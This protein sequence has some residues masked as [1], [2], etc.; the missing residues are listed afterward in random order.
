[1]SSSNQSGDKGPLA[2]RA[3]SK[4]ARKQEARKTATLDK[5]S[6]REFLKESEA[7]RESRKDGDKKDGGGE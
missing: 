7:P 2:P 6:L 4:Q 5:M 3:D 1:M